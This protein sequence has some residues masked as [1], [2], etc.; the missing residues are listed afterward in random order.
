M[1]VL[2]T[3]P[4]GGYLYHAREMGIDERLDLTALCGYKP[5][6]PTGHIIRGR[7]CWTPSDFMEPPS[8]RNTCGNCQTKVEVMQVR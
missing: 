3:R 1:P 8:Q 5:S 2:Y 7:G 6:S 4:N